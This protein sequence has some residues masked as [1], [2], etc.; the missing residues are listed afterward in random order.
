[1]CSQDL[2]FVLSGTTSEDLFEGLQSY[3]RELVRGISTDYIEAQGAVHHG[4]LLGSSSGS[5]PRSILEIFLR[6]R[7]IKADHLQ[8]EYVV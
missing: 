2:R 8:N 4:L 6:S 1:M 7:E 3:F 5:C